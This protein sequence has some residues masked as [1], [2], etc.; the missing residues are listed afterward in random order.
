MYSIC[1]VRLRY[2]FPFLLCITRNNIQ[3]CVHL[4]SAVTSQFIGT[5]NRQQKI[6]NRA[7]HIDRSSAYGLQ[8]SQADIFYIRAT[9][10]NSLNGY[11]DTRIIRNCMNKH[12]DRFSPLFLTLKKETSTE[13]RMRITPDHRYI[14]VRCLDGELCSGATSVSIRNDAA[15]RPSVT[16][17]L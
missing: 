14:W 11:P 12:G 17:F 2:F 1:C 6:I 13:N 8:M 15:K 3:R 5:F 9:Y 10:R 16:F 7:R 4:S